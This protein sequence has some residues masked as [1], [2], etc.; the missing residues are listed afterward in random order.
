M[1]KV[2]AICFTLSTFISWQSAAQSWV[3]ETL[4]FD[5]RLVHAMASTSKGI[6]ILEGRLVK[7]ERAKTMIHLPIQDDEPSQE[8]AP[9]ARDGHSLDSDEKGELLSFGGINSETVLNEL[10]KY[11]NQTW[12]LIAPNGKVPPPRWGHGAVFFDKKLWIFG[13]QSENQ[14]EFLQDLWSWDGK[15]WTLHNSVLHPEPRYGC[16]LGVHQGKLI[17]YGGRNHSGDWFTDTWVWDNNWRKLEP[18]KSTPKP[19]ASVSFALITTASDLY[20]IGGF[21]KGDTYPE[22]WKLDEENWTLVTNKLPF[23][24]DFPAGC[25]NAVTNSLILAGSANGSF[26]LWKY[27]LR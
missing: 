3:K 10:W 7:G 21:L 24:L 8:N 1:Q 16:Q 27:Q 5:A 23:N 6:Y 2:L 9:N 26:E 14:S 25:F 20:L 4:P 22:M 17:L 12:H 11:E 18:K 19:K 15:T 13:G